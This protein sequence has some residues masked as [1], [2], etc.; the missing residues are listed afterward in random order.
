MIFSQLQSSKTERVALINKPIM[1][2]QATIGMT[3]TLLLHNYHLSNT[4]VIMYRS[5]VFSLVNRYVWADVHY[6]IFLMLGLPIPGFSQIMDEDIKPIDP[7]DE[8][9][10]SDLRDMAIQRRSDVPFVRDSF[11]KSQIHPAYHF[12]FEYDAV[13]DKNGHHS[14]PNTAVSQKRKRT[15][16]ETAATSTTNK[17]HAIVSSGRPPI[18]LEQPPPSMPDYNSHSAFMAA[19]EHQ[20]FLQDL[21]QWP[22][23]M[24]GQYFESMSYE[25]LDEFDEDRSKTEQYWTEHAELFTYYFP[26][27]E[28]T[29]EASS[30]CPF[31]CEEAYYSRD[32]ERFEA[33]EISTDSDDPEISIHA[34]RPHRGQHIAADFEDMLEHSQEYG[35]GSFTDYM[36]GHGA[37]GAMLGQQHNYLEYQHQWQAHGNVPWGLQ[38]QYTQSFFAFTYP[39]E[40]Q[41]WLLEQ[42][43]HPYDLHQPQSPPGWEQYQCTQPIYTPEYHAWYQEMFM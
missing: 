13:E 17:R 26:S 35:S 4:Q 39:S 34:P 41:E 25:E 2:D 15:N 9:S 5:M 3:T 10:S 20:N 27:S 14:G 42:Q 29:S 33:I 7:P 12:L 21:R 8:E 28:S 32:H 11:Q 18:A 22:T 38:P 43:M 23:W 1:H 31:G 16:E 24:A 30:S 36:S 37:S 40:Q 19:Y 6:S